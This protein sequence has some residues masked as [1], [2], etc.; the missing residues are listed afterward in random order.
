[1]KKFLKVLFYVIAAVY[2]VLVFTLLVIF[3]VDTR[4]LSL[5]IIALAAAF[6]LSATGSKKTRNEKE[7]SNYTF[8]GTCSGHPDAE[9]FGNAF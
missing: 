9:S 3:K 4:I 5:C 8:H 6:F 2:P 7:K 1:M